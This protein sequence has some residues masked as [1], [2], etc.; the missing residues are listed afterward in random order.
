MSLFPLLARPTMLKLPTLAAPPQVQVV[1]RAAAVAPVPAAPLVAAP[2][3][4][5]QR[6]TLEW[7]ALA[8][9]SLV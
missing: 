6:A 1:L 5:P 8:D 4:L 2:E 7:P 9:R 3:L